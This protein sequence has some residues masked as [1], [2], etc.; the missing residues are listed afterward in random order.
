MEGEG[1]REREVVGGWGGWC[2]GGGIEQ[3]EGW[4]YIEQ[5]EGW[6]YRAFCVE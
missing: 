6:G 2:G 1:E 3:W 4:G 5:W